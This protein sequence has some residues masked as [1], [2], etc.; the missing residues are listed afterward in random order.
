[1]RLDTR[2]TFKQKF[3]QYEILIDCMNNKIPVHQEAQKNMSQTNKN[4]D[5]LLLCKNYLRVCICNRIIFHEKSLVNNFIFFLAHENLFSVICDDDAFS[6]IFIGL[7]MHT[8]KRD[9]QRIFFSVAPQQT[10]SDRQLV[11]KGSSV[12][13]QK[14]V[15]SKILTQKS[16]KTAWC[17]LHII[18]SPSPVA[19]LPCSLLY[20]L[21][22]D[23]KL[24]GLL[25]F[26]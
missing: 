26:L 20:V 11:E 17:I 24:L 12:K 22:T 1:M 7:H 6:N 14:R 21:F 16:Y 4:K 25:H 5:E 18:S 3:V 23:L 2:V 15:A 10:N 8:P 19:L 13:H 9:K